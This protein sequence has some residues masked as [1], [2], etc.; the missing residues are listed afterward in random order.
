MGDKLTKIRVQLREQGES[1]WAEA[2]G[3]NLYRVENFLILPQHI[4]PQDVVRCSAPENG[5][6]EV[7][8][9]VERGPW[10]AVGVIF[11]KDASDDLIYKVIS[12][13]HAQ[14]CVWQQL[15]KRSYGITVPKAKFRD[16]LRIL[17]ATPRAVGWE[18]VCGPDAPTPC[19]AFDPPPDRT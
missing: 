17:E 1:F 9:V 10:Y 12:D 16:I 6:P 14:G 7:L 5:L 19:S 3:N 8:E 11:D 2:L 15:V 4:A 13:L 18:I